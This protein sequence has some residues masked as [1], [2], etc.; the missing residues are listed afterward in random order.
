V[1]D[2]AERSAD[3]SDMRSIEMRA[4]VRRWLREEQGARDG[5]FF[6]ADVHDCIPGKCALPR[7]IAGEV[8]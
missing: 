7:L 3:V 2:R 8:I 1:I 6:S 4:A 5:N